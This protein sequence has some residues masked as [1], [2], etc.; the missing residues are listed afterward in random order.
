M[1]SVAT[2]TRMLLGVL[3]WGGVLLL[4]QTTLFRGT[5]TP[6]EWLAYFHAK[7][8]V[9]LCFAQTLSYRSLKSRL[10]SVFYS[11]TFPLSHG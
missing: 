7:H 11:G 8:V 9:C 4:F 5:H 1:A 10:A 2:L 6:L 3:S